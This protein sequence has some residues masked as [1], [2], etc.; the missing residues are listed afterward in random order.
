MQT[1]KRAADND[2]EGNT[3]PNK[4]TKTFGIK[5]VILSAEGNKLPLAFNS[6]QDKAHQFLGGLFEDDNG[7]ASVAIV[8]AAPGTAATR[9]G[10]V[11][12]DL[13]AEP[14][15][16]VRISGLEPRSNIFDSAM[17]EHKERYKPGTVYSFTEKSVIMRASAS[18]TVR[19][20][21]KNV[22]G[23]SVVNHHPYIHGVHTQIH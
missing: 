7:I 4:T 21:L 19:P 23:P 5:F 11:M 3:P 2:W 12:S 15:I 1:Q 14:G 13:N 20:E 9:L 8:H 16:T 10:E 6:R 18:A 22:S 17:W